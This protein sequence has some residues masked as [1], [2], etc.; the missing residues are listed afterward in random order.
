MENYKVFEKMG[1]LHQM[2][3]ISVTVEHLIET[4]YLQSRTGTEQN[5]NRAETS[6]TKF[7][8]FWYVFQLAVHIK[9]SFIRNWY[10]QPVNYTNLMS[11]ALHVEPP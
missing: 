5:W 11:D 10:N 8:V 9:M 1:L 2:L 6:Y 3:L 4:N 7:V